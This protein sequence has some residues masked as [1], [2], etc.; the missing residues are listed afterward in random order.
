MKFDDILENHVGS[1]GRYQALLI[2][3][4][5]VAGYYSNVF[6]M[7]IVFSAGKMDY[8]CDMQQPMT[9]LTGNMSHEEQLQHTK[10]W[11]QEERCKPFGRNRSDSG[12]IGALPNGST[13]SCNDFVYD[14]ST[15]KSTI[16][17]E[18]II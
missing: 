14:T 7:E 4:L 6:T 13:S 17:S 5:S 2:G 12:Q 8:W 3:L 11:S 9:S 18:V 1:L 15:F 10:G 16:V